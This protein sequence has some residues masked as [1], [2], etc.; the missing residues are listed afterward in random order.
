MASNQQKKHNNYTAG[1]CA[2]R[3]SSPGTAKIHYYLVGLIKGVRVKKA[4]H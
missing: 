2:A 4:L 1:F 3:E